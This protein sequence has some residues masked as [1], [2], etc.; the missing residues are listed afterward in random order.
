M[1]IFKKGNRSSAVN[2]RPISLT[3]ILCKLC[4]HIVHS[5]IST[6]LDCNSILTNAQHGFRKRRSCE[7]QLLL[8]LDDL[9]KGLDD[10]S[11]TDMIL[12]DFSKAF[13]KVPHQ[14]LLLKVSHCGISG[15][16]L[17]WIEDFLH[18]R[19]QR[20]VL[21]GQSSSV[22]PVTSGV[23][24]GS[25]LGPLLFLIY[26]NDLPDSVASS[27][28]RLFADDTV[29]YRRISSPADASNLQYDLDALQAWEATWMME[30]NPA[31]CQLLRVTLKRKPVEATYTVHGQALEAVDAAKYLGVTIDS[32]LSFNSH[33]DSVCKKANGTRAFLNRN[34]SSCSRHVRDLTY[35][36]YVRPQLEYAS[37]VWDPSTRKNVNQLEQ[38]QRHAARYVTGNYDTNSSVTAMLRDLEWPTLEQRRHHSRLI[39]MYKNFNR[40]VGIDLPAS[41]TRTNANTRGHSSRIL[42]YS[43]S[44]NAY[45][46]S[47]YPRTSR[48]WNAL[49][50]DPLLCQ[51]VDSFKNYLCSDSPPHH[52]LF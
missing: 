35:K 41:L 50:A 18:G 38:V 29:L 12:L 10:K 22:A 36:T 27:T 37:T 51:S 1:P 4:E 42:E 7:T 19:T 8:T 32:K 44:C 23:P 17:A 11:Q 46:S 20:V 26:I 25:V 49:S 24:Q 16:V 5:T 2:Y 43:C 39:M 40:L 14:R 21:D 13:D 3:S 31:K 6:H 30:F 47:F 15:S 45:A 48:D 33:I 52:R 9:A 28:V 34:L